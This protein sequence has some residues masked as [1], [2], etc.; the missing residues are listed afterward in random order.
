[1]YLV[2]YGDFQTDDYN[3]AEWALFILATCAMPLIMLNLLIAI[4]SDTYERVTNNM[5][6]AD[7]KELNSL[8]LEQERQMFW[9]RNVDEKTHIHWAVTID[10][11][12]AS[13]W[14]GKVQALKNAF[15]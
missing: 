12:A 8:I 13:K 10:N 3:A 4:M 1:V 15:A 6:E 2:A 11:S 9:N 7:G 14:A 5:E